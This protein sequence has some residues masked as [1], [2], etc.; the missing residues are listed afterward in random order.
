MEIQDTIHIGHSD[1]ALALLDQLLMEN[2][3]DQDVAKV[4][5]AIKDALERGII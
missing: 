2:D 4:L 5:R 3:L 1:D